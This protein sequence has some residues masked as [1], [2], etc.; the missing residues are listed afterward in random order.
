M[1]KLTKLMAAAITIFVWMIAYNAFAKENEIIDKNNGFAGEHGIRSKNMSMCISNNTKSPMRV[2]N[3]RI[4]DNRSDRQYTGVLP[5]TIH[6][7][8]VV[9]LETPKSLGKKAGAKATFIILDMV[10]QDR[11]I[12]YRWSVGLFCNYTPKK[13]A[14]T[15]RDPIYK[16]NTDDIKDA[17]N[18]NMPAGH[19]AVLNKKTW[20]ENAH[21]GASEYQ[22]V[23]TELVPGYNWSAGGDAKIES[24]S[25]ENWIGS[26][27]LIIINPFKL[28]NLG[29]GI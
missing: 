13:N 27:T 6:Q 16:K 2:D 7:G 20:W 21:P 17:I 19:K 14:Y 3:V 26:G 4:S 23:S 15:K 28:Q 24:W 9:E 29:F 8:D 25:T 18:K 11:G 10:Q 5:I 12:D 1:K 22:L